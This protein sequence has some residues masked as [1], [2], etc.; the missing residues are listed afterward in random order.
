MNE[1]IVYETERL[2]L[3]P[4]VESDAPFILKLLTTPKFLKF[5]GDREVRTLDQAK[6]YIRKKMLPQLY[7]LGYGNYA[8]VRK[9]D[10]TLVGTCGLHD[11]KG[12]EGVDIGFAFLPEYEGKGY[13]FESANK[14]KK[15]AITEFGI[16][17]ILG[18]TSRNNIS[19]RKLLEKLGLRFQRMI[20]L[21]NEDK[22]ICLYSYSVDSNGDLT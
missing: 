15:V 14:V 8:V 18:V 10:G 19:S 9:S 12:L 20:T 2:F 5:I 1:P 13:A 11:R 17:T 7:R 3:R 4:V 21:P 22:E 16:G 6:K